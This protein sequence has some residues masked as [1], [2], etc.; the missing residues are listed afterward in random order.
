MKTPAR[1]SPYLG[2]MV[3]YFYH[4]VQL[5]MHGAVKIAGVRRIYEQSLHKK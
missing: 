3:D 4:A 1:K 5:L 2:I